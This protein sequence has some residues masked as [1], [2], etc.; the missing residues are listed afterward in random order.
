[1]G[2]QQIISGDGNARLEFEQLHELP[3]ASTSTCRD[4]PIM[5]NCMSIIDM[6]MDTLGITRPIETDAVIRAQLRAVVEYKVRSHLR[7]YLPREIERV[8]VFTEDDLDSL[9]KT[10][11]RKKPLTQEEYTRIVRTA[12]LARAHVGNEPVTIVA[13]VSDSLYPSNVTRVAD[14][15]RIMR[16]RG[17]RVRPFAIGEAVG[18]SSVK[19]LAASQGVELCLGL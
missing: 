6:S 2:V 3:E 12:I 18:E 9:L 13:E 8:K 5:L 16:A 14:A 17:Q 4:Y 1:M 11:N 7:G 15:A 19:D 10:L